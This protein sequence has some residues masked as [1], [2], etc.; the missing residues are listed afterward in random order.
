MNRPFEI[1]F[2]ITSSGEV[3][4]ESSQIIDGLNPDEVCTTLRRNQVT[5]PGEILKIT[6]VTEWVPTTSK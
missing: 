4:V 2:V 3:Q 6:K 5:L 1:W